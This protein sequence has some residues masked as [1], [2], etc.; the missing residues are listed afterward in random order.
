MEIKNTSGDAEDQQS[1]SGIRGSRIVL[2]GAILLL[3]ACETPPPPSAVPPP[4]ASPPS[5]EVYF[6]PTK[7]QSKAQQDRDRYECYLWAKEQTG[8]DPS[9]PNL[10]PH[11]RVR[12]VP[13]A[14]PG[15]AAAAGAITG[16]VLG[17]AISRP[18]EETEGAVKGAIAGAIVGAAAQS[19]REQQARQIEQQQQAVLDAQRAARLEQQ[20]SNYRRAMSACLKGRGYEVR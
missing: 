14:P 19:S 15:D 20:A 5:V 1:R 2:I 16:A 3:A 10:A 17:A 13:T 8:F 7:G 6:Y 18:G 9:A 11:Q 12:V 4:A